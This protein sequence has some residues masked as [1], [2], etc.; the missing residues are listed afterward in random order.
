MT[1]YPFRIQSALWPTVLVYSGLL[2]AL[3]LMMSLLNRELVNN[4][5]FPIAQYVPMF[6]I[7]WRD[8]PSAAIGVLA[9]KSVLAFGHFDE[10]SGLYLWTLEFDTLSLL[11]YLAVSFV[12][13][14]VWHRIRAT[15]IDRMQSALALA[16][17]GL[18]LLARTYATVAAH[19]AGS[20][21]VGFV[22]LYALGVDK[23]PVNSF[24][25]WLFA[26]A[27]LALLAVF[28]FSN[29]SGAMNRVPTPPV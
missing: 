17:L 3:V 24:W 1:S 21:W 12:A 15:G 11:V 26:A 10:R 25:Q 22:S 29:Q 6:E 23:F 2:V 16:G 4:V 28:Y 13:V 5:L 9:D 19:C 7:L 14:V 8:N 18:I 27:G 20:T